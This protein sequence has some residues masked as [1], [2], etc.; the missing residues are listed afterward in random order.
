MSR[1]DAGKAEL[2]EAFKADPEVA[3]D[4]DLTT[5]EVE[6][7]FVTVAVSLGIE[8]KWAPKEATAAGKP[9][10]AASRAAAEGDIVHTPPAEQAVSTPVPLYVEAAPGASFPKGKVPYRPYW[11]P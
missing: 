7:A 6:T 1:S 3:L 8:P 2:A 11:C 5:P 9:S 4:P 10:G